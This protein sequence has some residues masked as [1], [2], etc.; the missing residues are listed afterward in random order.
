M[1]V[2]KCDI[3]GKFY[4]GYGNQVMH[5]NVGIRNTDCGD[6]FYDFCPECATLIKDLIETMENYGDKY[7]I[8]IIAHGEEY[9]SENT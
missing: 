7:H 3:C 1:R 2:F 9:R 4:D 6:V 8:R 5:G